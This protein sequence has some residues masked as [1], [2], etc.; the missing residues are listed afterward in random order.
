MLLGLSLPLVSQHVLVGSC[1]GVHP[2]MRIRI[3]GLF[4]HN[5]LPN[6]NV[7]F[8]D[9]SLMLQSLLQVV[10]EWVLGA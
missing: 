4:D 6:E 7:G 1:S 5:D 2:P 8:T 9:E 10:L 3:F